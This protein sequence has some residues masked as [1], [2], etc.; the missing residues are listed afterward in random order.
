MRSY[1]ASFRPM[2]S[3]NMP[4]GRSEPAIEVAVQWACEARAV[5]SEQDFQRWA[6][7]ALA[8]RREAAELT[9]RVV[10][11]EESR[12]L[13]RAYRGQDKPTNVLSFP[14]EAPP[15]V[16]ADGLLGDLV[17]CADIIEREAAEQGKLVSAHWAHMVV[18][19]VLHLLGYDHQEDRAAEVMEAL[20]VEVLDG[21]GVRDPYREGGVD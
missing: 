8:G 7:A 15:G 2:I 9:V 21:L 16:D 10:G 20:E 14:F 3:T 6:V 17:I 19:G 11:P 1:S 18:H 4:T 12:A 13:N 5:P